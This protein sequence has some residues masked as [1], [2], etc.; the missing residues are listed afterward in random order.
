MWIEDRDVRINSSIYDIMM[1]PC[2]HRNTVDAIL[3]I[4]DSYAAKNRDV[5]IK[6]G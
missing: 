6:L 5:I 1:L 2:A 4:Q 3:T